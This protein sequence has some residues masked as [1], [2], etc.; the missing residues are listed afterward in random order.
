MAK[1]SIKFYYDVVSPYSYVAFQLLRRYRAQWNVELI[2]EPMFLGFVLKAVGTPPP[3]FSKV[4]LPYMKKDLNRIKRIHTLENLLITPD[5][6]P[7]N[8]LRA[9]RLLQAVKTGGGTPTELERLTANLFDAYWLHSKDLSNV[10]LFPELVAKSMDQANGGD[11][12]IKVKIEKFIAAMETP[13]VKDGLVETGN[14]AVEKG[15]FGAPTMFVDKGDGVEE[16]FFGCDRLDHVADYL[17][18]KIPITEAKL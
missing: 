18:V 17:G 7:M 15:A 8:T 11:L 3:A 12:D 16:M 6:F 9:M 4:K 14:R 5:P 1:P 2:L 13:F 10:S